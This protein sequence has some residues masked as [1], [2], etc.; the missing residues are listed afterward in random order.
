MYTLFQLYIVGLISGSCGHKFKR[1]TWIESPRIRLCAFSL[2][3]CVLINQRSAGCTQA[4][5][6]EQEGRR[7]I[8]RLS[9]PPTLLK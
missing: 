5:R 2:C 1:R 9:D 4:A 8:A 6:I 7:E 3:G